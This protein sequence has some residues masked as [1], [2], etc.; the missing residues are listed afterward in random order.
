MGQKIVHLCLADISYRQVNLTLESKRMMAHVM[1]M[2]LMTITPHSV[3]IIQRYVQNSIAGLSG[4]ES[5][6]YYM[7]LLHEDQKLMD[8]IAFSYGWCLKKAGGPVLPLSLIFEVPSAPQ[9]P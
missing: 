1:E 8:A 2:T 5:I 6:R 7:Y 3:F 9:V 4:T